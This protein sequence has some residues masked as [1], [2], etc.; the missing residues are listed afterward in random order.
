MKN[1]SKYGEFELDING[2][3]K[4]H[5]TK[6]DKKRI[7]FAPYIAVTK[8]FKDLSNSDE[9]IVLVDAHGT[10]VKE[11][12]DI[13][14]TSNLPNLIKKGFIIDQKYV[15]DLSLALQ[16]MRNSIQ[17]IIQYKEIGLIPGHHEPLILLNQPYSASQLQYPT[18]SSSQLKIQPSGSFDEWMKMFD[19]HV[20]GNHKLELAAAIGISGL[21]NAFMNNK[22][23]SPLKSLMFHFVGNSSSGKT[24]SA[25]L[26]LSTA[27]SPNNET[28]S[29]YKNWNATTNSIITSV[30]DNH[31]IPILFDEVSMVNTNSLTSTIYSLTDGREKNR[32]NQDGTPKEVRTWNTVI[33]STGEYS[34]LNSNKTAKNDGLNVRVI[35]FD[36]PWTTSSN[37]SD[38]IKRIVKQH[39]GHI[40][41]LVANLLTKIAFDRLVNSYNESKSIMIEKLAE[42]KSNTG[43]R[44]SDY[45]A[46]ILLSVKILKYIL[47]KELQFDRITDE[48]IQYHWNTVSNRSLAEK[49]IDTITQFVLTNYAYFSRNSWL[50]NNF[51]NY[52][53]ISY[54]SKNDYIKADILKDVFN[55]MLIDNNFQ[56]KT[57]V[58]KALLSE[59]YLI[60]QEKDRNTIRHE[61][62][63]DNG[64]KRKAAFYSIKLDAS[65]AEAFGFPTDPSNGPGPLDDVFDSM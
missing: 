14:S 39:Y 6:K 62:T 48:L 47:K 50:N 53:F 20:L 35:E 43:S 10:S 29:L 57:V 60:T 4:Y 45:Y 64:Q 58:I 33:I 56:D 30:A 55:K 36:N 17:P 32:L 22:G 44:M 46:I 19:T 23:I 8:R 1:V 31:G 7:Y 13:L 54:D 59:G 25:M 65:H 11:S 41:P 37:N 40:L 49:A 38:E 52:G 21:V 18:E 63:D 16:L 2:W 12:S 3:H 15:A 5:V 9:V 42:D 26:A 27:G 34:I 61:Y 24:T 28:T 51:S